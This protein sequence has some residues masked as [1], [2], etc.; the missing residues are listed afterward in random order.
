VTIHATKPQDAI[1]FV[2]NGLWNDI[3]GATPVGGYV[4]EF[5]PTE[6]ELL[7]FTINNSNVPGG[8]PVIGKITLTSFAP[9]GGAKVMLSNTNSA[10]MVPATVTVPAGAKT[11]TFTIATK[12]VATAQQGSITA[13]Y[14]TATDSAF[15]EVRPIRIK[16][17]TL[18][19]N[20]VVGGTA[21]QGLVILE[22]PAFTDTFV[23]LTSSDSKATVPVR[24][25]IAAG[26]FYRSFDVNTFAVGRNKTI[27]ISATTI[28]ATTNGATESATLI[29]YAQ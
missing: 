18:A 13:L 9:T 2:G 14:N 11:A 20:V 12:P 7:S 19:P 24:I 1:I 21:T 27:T 16:L 29:L 8:R 17:V 6:V 25:K 23:T 5:E 28:S 26:Q 3:N 15:L 22:A 10:A 4:V